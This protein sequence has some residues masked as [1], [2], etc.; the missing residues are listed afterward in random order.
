MMERA[1]ALASLSLLLAIPVSG[2]PAIAEVEPATDVDPT[3]EGVVP[4]WI[5]AD[6]ALSSDAALANAAEQEVSTAAMVAA[7]PV[8]PVLPPSTGPLLVAGAVSGPAGIGGGE[9]VVLVDDDGGL[10]DVVPRIPV[11]RLPLGS[12]GRFSVSPAMDGWTKG[13]LD[14]TGRLTLTLTGTF[15]GRAFVGRVERVWDAAAARWTDRDG[16]TDL[17][18]SLTA[19]MAMEALPAQTASSSSPRQYVGCSSVVVKKYH[20][21]ALVGEAQYSQRFVG[22][23]FQFSARGDVE[24]GVGIKEG[25]GGWAVE[26]TS[27]VTKSFAASNEFPLNSNEHRAVYAR[28]EYHDE[29][30]TCSTGYSVFSYVKAK[31]YAWEGGLWRGPS[32]PERYCGGAQAKY[33][34]EVEANGTFVRESGRAQTWSGGVSVHGLSLSSRAGYS[35]SVRQTWKAGKRATYVCGS[36]GSP[37]RASG[38]VFTSSSV[39]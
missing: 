12:D 8:D 17:R 38:R 32:I 20:V 4:A 31:P 2:R 29:K 11:A 16:G 25:A 13:H 10:G 7:V 22:G 3:L 36:N 26:G 30:T 15:G 23:T 28:F 34:A 1:G 14:Q 33:R 35:S 18:T 37:V 21:D 27:K 5:Q 6:L 9:L 39:R 19:S 24:L